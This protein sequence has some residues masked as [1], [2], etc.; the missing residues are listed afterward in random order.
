MLLL[1]GHNAAA[2][3][4]E[5]R[6][7][8]ARFAS[9]YHVYAPDLL[10]YG[11]S[12]R[13][14]ISYTP[15]LYVQLITDLLRDFVGAPAV[16]LASSLSSAYAI[17]VAALH[18]EL[19][20]SLVLVCPTGVRSLSEQSTAGAV[21]QALLTSP[22]LGQA[23]FN[24]LAS[25][26]SIQYFL[27]KQTYHDESLVTTGLIENYYRTAHVPG[28]RY[29]PAAFVGGGLY[30]DAT[31]AWQSLQVP[32]LIVWGR[33]AKITPPTNAAPFLATNPRAELREVPN[34]GLLP[35][36]EQPEQFTNL[37]LEWLAPIE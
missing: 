22:H 30:H 27:A 20:T 14:H 11:V 12:D 16:V 37:V 19:V 34:A 2:S 1:H 25:R 35:H 23:L 15:K 17:E 5:M 32:V 28:A 21:A 24:T 7:P 4:M 26:R 6:E 36:D 31:D 9:H 13:P 3:A 33:E 10:G 18:P 29:A 8:F